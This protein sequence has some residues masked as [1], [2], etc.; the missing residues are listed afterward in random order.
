MILWLT[1]VENARNWL[2]GNRLELYFKVHGVESNILRIS[3]YEEVVEEPEPEPEPVPGTQGGAESLMLSGVP[4]VHD[5]NFLIPENAITGD[6]V[7]DLNLMWVDPNQNIVFSIIDDDNGRFNIQK[8]TNRDTVSNHLLD[9][10]IRISV[11]NPSFDYDIQQEHQ[12]T[13]RATDQDTG[14]YRNSVI[15]VKLSDLDKTIFID[16]DYMGGNS[17]GSFEAP[18]TS[19]RNVSSASAPCEGIITPGWAY[20]QKRGSIYYGHSDH[21]RGFCSLTSG[22]SDEH[23]VLGAYGSGERPISDGRYRQASEVWWYE[24]AIGMY[25]EADYFDIYSTHL[26]HWWGGI[27]GEMNTTTVQD[28]HFSRLRGMGTYFLGDYT[29]G[30]G[31]DVKLF[32]D[33]QDCYSEYVGFSEFGYEADPINMYG[34]KTE[35]PAAVNFTYVVARFNRVTGFAGCG[36]TNTYTYCQA[37]ENGDGVKGYGIKAHGNGILID[38]TLIANNYMW[39][40][41]TNN[42]YHAYGWTTTN[43]HIK[44]SLIKNHPAK[45]DNGGNYISNSGVGIYA[46]G[47]PSNFIIENTEFEN[48]HLGIT[49][50]TANNK[51]GIPFAPSNFTIKNNIF[52]NN[53]ISV[54]AGYWYSFDSPWPRDLLIYHNLFYD[55][56]DVSVYMPDSRR[57]E[58]YNNVFYNNDGSS[59]VY[60]RRDE[61]FIAKNNLL[62]DSISVSGLNHIVEYNLDHEDSFF[63]DAASRNFHLAPGSPAIEAGV[64]I[65]GFHCVTSGEHPNEDCVEWYGDAPDIGVFEYVPG[66]RTYYIDENGD[67][68]LGD[69]SLENPWASLA[70]A[71]SQANGIGS[72]IHVNSGTY[73]ETGQCLLAEGVNIEGEGDSS[74]IISTVNTIW[75]PT[76]KLF[77][78]EQGTNGNQSISYIKL[79]GNNEAWEAMWI[80]ARS[81]VLIHHC[82]IVNFFHS[83]V[84]FNA[85]S[86]TSPTKGSPTIYATGNKFYDNTL[87]NSSEFTGETGYGELMIGGQEGIEIYNNYMSTLGRA[88]RKSGYNIKY[89]SDGYHKG[90]K[91]Y[92]NTFITS[93]EISANPYFIFS[94]ELWHSQGGIQIYNNTMTAGIDFAGGTINIGLIKGDYEYGA[95]VHNNI[96]GPNTIVSG[97]AGLRLERNTDNAIIENNLFKNLYNGIVLS[98]SSGETI[99]NHEIRYNLFNNMGYY[100]I[101]SSNYITGAYADSI[102]IY[103]NVV[104]TPSSTTTELVG[105]SLMDVG[106]TTNINVSNN[107]IQG[108]GYTPIYAS[109]DKGQTINGLIIQ[110]NIMYGNAHSNTPLFNT[111]TPTNYIYKNNLEGV[112][113]LFVS[114]GVDFHLQSTSPAIDAGIDVGLITDYDGNPIVGLPDI[115]AFEYV[116]DSCDDIQCDADEYCSRGVCLLDVTGDTFF[117]APDGDDNN[118]GL[119]LDT[120]WK[121]WGK[122]FNDVNVDAGDI[123]YF[124]GGVYYKD[125]SEGISYWYYPSSSSGGT[126]Y[127]ITR[128]GTA[129]SWLYY[130]NYP[131]EIPI[132]DCVNAYNPAQRL[133]YGIRTGNSVNYVH[134]KGLQMKNVVQNPAFPGDELGYNSSKVVGWKMGGHYIIENSVVYNTGGTG[135]SLGGANAPDYSYVINCD[136]YNNS[137]SLTATLPGNDGYGF[138]TMEFGGQLYFKDCRAWLCGDYGFAAGTIYSSSAD[139]YVVYD[140]CWA[141]NNGLLEGGGQGFTMGWIAYTDGNLKRTYKNNIAAYNRQ[142][143]WKSLDYKYPWAV[144][145]NL[146]NNIGYHNGW[147]GGAPMGG[148]DGYFI[149]MDNTLDTSAN[150]LLRVLKNNIAY[151]N[152]VGVVWNETGGIYTHSNNSWD[153][154]VTVT[155]DD[156]VLL[157]ET[158]EQGFSLLSAE[159]Q[160][161][162]SLPDLGNYFRL[163]EGSDLIDRGTFIPGFHCA[164]AGN[165]PDEDCVEWYGDAPDIGAFEY[166][167]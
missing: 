137:D 166:F 136:T 120:P 94:I 122:A 116:N 156:F 117:V 39:G 148:I 99:Q 50:Y 33:V 14:E 15:T 25:L 61:A 52:H 133:V 67:D 150:E 105:I 149:E 81:N 139:Q 19:W 9:Y 62:E 101:Y 88:E 30:Q 23:I 155:D 158:P 112:N 161:D 60:M 127:D 113:P 35:S 167:G 90:T 28:V 32:V 153:S 46:G 130:F 31:E 154:A 47:S 111:I 53:D 42:Y 146:Y 11:N 141:F 132:L 4:L 79:D 59:D 104:Y 26:Q 93:N 77:S 44:D 100:G 151:D 131:N 121:T 143:G 8:L 164:T 29:V 109:G 72:T 5:Q 27:N 114:P 102:N 16:P 129:D 91:I 108:F 126:G 125:L 165:H 110:N 34:F 69:G 138:E 119:T 12:L 49:F 92:N 65:P 70:Y 68:T 160:E 107:V 38:H 71:C 37:T 10:E 152:E 118:N 134:F 51:A 7:G 162:G 43:V 159:R 85:K 48:N 96:I 20:L 97:R 36:G 128:D 22:T 73:T 18:F 86:E 64:H 45:Y 140:G 98:P 142:C 163:E 21:S 80:Y 56:E 103:N 123:V 124:R 58:V 1:H 74:Y 84:T 55:N 145:A 17:D 95:W 83:G 89:F 66:P 135:F 75:T 2:E 57:V 3:F 157:P 144:Y 115:G 41:S 63:V 87:L 6:T 82:T 106:T 54:R 78:N 13:I 147:Q 40:I 24:W 76:I